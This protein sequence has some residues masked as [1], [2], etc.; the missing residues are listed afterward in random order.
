MR[1]VPSVENGPVKALPSG[2]FSPPLPGKYLILYR[3]PEWR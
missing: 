3:I 2:P 1:F